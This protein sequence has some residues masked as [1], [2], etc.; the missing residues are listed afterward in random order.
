MKKV[1]GAMKTTR[2]FF[3][4]L[5]CLLGAAFFLAS[6]LDL[7]NLSVSAGS[8][9]LHHEVTRPLC[10]LLSK[11][12][13]GLL[14]A[15]IALAVLGRSSALSTA[16]YQD[17]A[18][19]VFAGLLFIVAGIVLENEAFFTLYDNKTLPVH[20]TEIVMNPAGGWITIREH[21]GLCIAGI[22]GATVFFGFTRY[23]V[24]QLR[25]RKEKIL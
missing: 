25:L 23:R 16:I 8:F 13:F 4:G 9:R 10:L 21:V 2:H 3:A 19:L 12:M 7:A 5:F 14:F 17:I 11:F 22:T 1:M 18:A 20:P 6:I 15:I 24:K